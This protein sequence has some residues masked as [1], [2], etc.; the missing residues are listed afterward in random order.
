MRIRPHHA[1]CAQ[2]FSGKG[3]NEQFVDHMYRVLAELNREGAIVTLTDECDEV[4]TVCPNNRCGSC[5]TATKVAAIDRRASD[6][7]GLKPGDILPWTDLCA[8]ARRIIIEPGRLP[9]ICGDCEWIGIC[10]G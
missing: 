9:E 2:F 3:Y 6:A 10:N 1:L 5:E 4:C 8:L 7:M